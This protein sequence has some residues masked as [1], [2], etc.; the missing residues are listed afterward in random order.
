MGDVPVQWFATLG[1]GGIIAAF[2]FL[3]YR[4]DLRRYTEMW[5]EQSQ[6]NREVVAQVLG[7]VKDNT[8]VLSKLISTVDSLHRRL[9]G[10]NTRNFP[11]RDQR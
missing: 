1:V 5:K 4:Q 8:E 11:Q 3:F 6:Q 10:N 2:M 9:D 7:V